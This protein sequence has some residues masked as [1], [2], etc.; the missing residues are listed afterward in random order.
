MNKIKTLLALL[1]SR[2]SSIMSAL[3]DGVIAVAVSATAA[4][5]RSAALLPSTCFFSGTRTCC[6]LTTGNLGLTVA[7]VALEIAL[8]RLEFADAIFLC[9]VVWSIGSLMVLLVCF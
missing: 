7:A 5:P 3:A 4:R 1:F 2:Y 8:S 9:E 6:T